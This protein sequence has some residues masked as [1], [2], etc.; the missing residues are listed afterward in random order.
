MSILQIILLA[1]TGAMA[2]IILKD[3]VPEI[4]MIIGIVT[5]GIILYFGMAKAVSIIE[6]VQTVASSYN[7]NSEYIAIVIKII[8]I[9]YL[10]EFIISALHD[11]GESGIASKVEMFSKLVIVSMAVPIFLSLAQ[12]VYTVLM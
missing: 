12:T 9:T 11:A 10:S 8:G 3:V 6:T 4:S 5:G 1:L 7:I 2:S